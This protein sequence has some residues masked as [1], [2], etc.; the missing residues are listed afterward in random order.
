[1]RLFQ[2]ISKLNSLSK[3]QQGNWCE[4]WDERSELKRYSNNKIRNPLNLIRAHNRLSR[5]SSTTTSFHAKP[6]RTH[7]PLWRATIVGRST[8]HRD[9]RTTGVVHRNGGL[10][11]CLVIGY[12]HHYRPIFRLH[13][14][15]RVNT[16]PVKIFSHPVNG[17]LGIY[18]PESL[19][20]TKWSGM[21]DQ[22]WVWW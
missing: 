10:C 3:N 6:P 9:V 11:I 22:W 21:P 8:Y 7:S 12:L 19:M 15:Y 18:R 20:S 13:L 16:G 4:R 1:M 2:F 17:D 5:W 14:R